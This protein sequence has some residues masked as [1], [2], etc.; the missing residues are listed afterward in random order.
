VRLGKA[1]PQMS[2]QLELALFGTGE[3]PTEFGSEEAESAA[4]G[5]MLPGRECGLLERIV[6]DLN[7]Q[8]A[9]KRVKKNKGRPGV[10]GI[11]VTDLD[12]W[13]REN[14]ERVRSELVSGRYVPNPVLRCEIA[15]TG[16]GVRQLGIPTVVDRVIQQMILQVLT[17]IFDPT[18]S[19]WSF[20]FRP[21]R[22]AHGAIVAAHRMVQS[23]RKIVVDV[24]LKTFF[25]RVQHDVLMERLS[26][27]IGDRILL[28]LIRR[29]LQAGILAKG[30]VIE[31]H[32]GTP[33]GGPLSP[34]LANILLDEVDKE[35]ERRGHQFAR[36]ADDCNVY[37]HS[38]AAGHRVM[39]LLRRLYGRL[40]LEVNEEKSAVGKADERKFLG[41][42]FWFRPD[43]SVKLRV[44][45]KTKALFKSELRSMT[46][47]VRGQ[48]LESVIKGLRPK[49]IGWKNYFRL[50]DQ[51]GFFRDMDKWIRHRLR[52]L[53]LKQWKCPIRRKR[54]VDS[55]QSGR[56]PWQS[57]RLQGTR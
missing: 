23:G 54:P 50:S 19:E 3:T 57:E 6:T 18:F 26:R 27:R 38:E 55:E 46:K 47:R 16:G 36:Y 10:D 22:S 13:F 34:L 44:A 8:A 17:P 1:M 30:V 42:S 28:K 11:S 15:K 40:R 43:G 2:E 7:L 9:L 49:L 21:G 33:Q 56:V 14:W 35:L 53:R 32:E 52:A 48:S 31:R 12:A 39:A 4:H 51:V 45:D 29:Y 24:D 41:Y 37:V 20:G 5:D 25:D